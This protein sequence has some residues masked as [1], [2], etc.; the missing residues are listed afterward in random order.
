MEKHSVNNISPLR[1]PGGKTRARKKLAQIVR[2]HFNDLEG[3]TTLVSPFVGGGS[4]EFYLQATLAI[5]LLVAN[6]IFAPLIRFWES[7]KG[8]NLEL[9]D[10]IEKVRGEVDKPVFRE[11]QNRIMGTRER[12]EQGVMFFVINRCS[13][14]GATLSGG[15]SQQSADKRF[16]LSSVDRVRAL[17]LSNVRFH[18]LDFEN[19]L[20]D[21]VT[22]KTF[23][24][25]DPPYALPESKSNVL[26]GKQGDAHSKFDHARLAQCVKKLGCQWMMT[27]NKC[28][29]IEEMYVG[30]TILDVDWAYSMNA[31]KPSS[32]IVILSRN[33]GAVK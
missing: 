26:Y 18:N 5:P 12:V 17:D 16:T 32:E 24:F 11:Y 30:H 9:C 31:G 23:V 33:S 1:Y 2:D 22:E 21:H 10:R 29:F 27:Y 13:F 19:F 4:F 3:V 8:D 28:A 15:F 25:L 14:S 7:A 6:D 20:Y